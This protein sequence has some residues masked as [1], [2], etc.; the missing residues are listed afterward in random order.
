MLPL[1]SF[2][3]SIRLFYSQTIPVNQSSLETVRYRNKSSMRVSWKSLWKECLL[4]V[5]N[6]IPIMKCMSVMHQQYEWVGRD[7][8]KEVGADTSTNFIFPLGS[9]FLSE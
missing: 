7:G 9:H 5:P 1:M 3:G 2:L 6:S 8:F 4:N